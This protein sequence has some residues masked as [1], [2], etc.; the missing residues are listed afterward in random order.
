[1][2]NECLKVKF[3]GQTFWEKKDKKKTPYQKVQIE[4]SWLFLF[5]KFVKC[6]EQNRN[7]DE[8]AG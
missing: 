3:S 8:K 6:E 4:N 2:N 7:R 5:N 1:M